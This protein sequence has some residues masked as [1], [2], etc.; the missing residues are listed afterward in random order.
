MKRLFSGDS[1]LLP[2]SG[3]FASS[4]SPESRSPSRPLSA[5]YNPDE[6]SPELSPIVTLL[7]AHSHRR[8]LEGVFM[9][10]ND[11]TSDGKPGE[12]QWEEVYGVLAG[13]QLA[14]WDANKLSKYKDDPEKL[15]STSS[16]P[17]YINFTDS[18]FRAVD[19][20]PSSNGDLN[21]VII[22]STTLKNRYLLQYSTREDYYRW[23]AAFRLATYEY[24]CLQEAYTGALLSARGSRL[25]DIRVILAET[26]YEHEDWVSVRFGSGMP[27]KRCFAVIEPSP[28]KSK[29]KFH[30][31][32]VVF[33]ENEKKSK[34]SAMAT[35]TGATACYAV[36]PQTPLLMDHSTLIKLEGTIAFHKN[37]SK[38]ASVFLM[39]E[40][41]FSVPGF[42]TII[43]FLMPTLDAFGLYGRPKKLVADKTQPESLLFG[44]PVLP[45]VHYLEVDDILP[46]SSQPSGSA[47]SVR[48]WNHAIK[49][50]LQTKLSKGYTGCG[51]TTGLEGAV[52][53]LMVSSPTINDFARPGAKQAP[54]LTPSFLPTPTF[55]NK[56]GQFSDGN[57]SS[58]SSISSADER[59]A[60]SLRN[61]NR[62]SEIYN[63]YSQIDS[64]SVYPNVTETM[65]KLTLNSGKSKLSDD[66]LAPAK[67]PANIFDP[68]FG[69]KEFNDN[70]SDSL[71]SL[72]FT[73]KRERIITPEVSVTLSSPAFEKPPGVRN[74]AL[75]QRV[76]SPYSEFHQQ[77]NQT[78]GLSLARS[79][80]PLTQ[81]K[82][83]PLPLLSP[84]G[85]QSS[86]G[87]TSLH[88]LQP[89]QRLPKTREQQ[90]ASPIQQ[91]APSNNIVP[92][93]PSQQPL[94]QQP[95]RNL[96]PTNAYGQPQNPYLDQKP[97]TPMGQQFQ[98]N[99]SPIKSP[100]S[101]PYP[102]GP[103]YGS[104]PSS[105]QPLS[106]TQQQFPRT[107]PQG[108][109]PPP[110][111]GYRQ[112]QPYP[113]NNYFNQPAP[114]QQ[115]QQQQ[116]PYPG[117]GYPPSQ[118]RAYPPSQGYP[119][120]SQNQGYPPQQQYY[121]QSQ[122]QQAY[123]RP[124]P[125]QQQ[126][127]QQQPPKMKKAPPPHMA[128]NPY[129]NPYAN[130]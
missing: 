25:S 3:L 121:Q 114:Q 26:K 111:Q 122:P 18:S 6:I 80:Q 102:T 106:L 21:N 65:S 55:N 126:Q 73:A 40:Q 15:I 107:Q 57:S 69:D 9:L 105:S 71:D 46:I 13:T 62:L 92:Q 113:T 22:V 34:K 99:E 66:D 14:V 101:A 95:M 100:S 70:G 1:P 130:N 2:G 44:L 12:R 59:S 72:D 128:Q 120:Q 123:G 37:D 33:Y 48:D 93:K 35:I 29:K 7:S 94:Q 23:N 11:L 82:P 125:Q 53:S 60:K 109:R 41:H 61:S 68:S 83:V 81:S 112:A 45:H 17:S 10:L 103:A 119:P 42:D 88:L 115:Q 78:V 63:K 118:Q 87:N 86:P 20:L 129:S 28:K 52:S 117:Q 75:T 64:P 19:K 56:S 90:T 58:K 85:G 97:I 76:L 49:S 43:R 50:V 67:A 4:V 127:Q 108:P 77:V 54:P 91:R 16:K 36:Y 96:T 74:E 24:A 116:R 124:P 47:M 104:S 89:P 31:G 27:W 32:K 8:Y 39:P 98:R 84:Y 51:S 79:Q 38:E 30:P 110:Q 5:N